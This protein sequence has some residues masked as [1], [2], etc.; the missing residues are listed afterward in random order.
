MAI[1]LLP[2]IR[3][4]HQLRIN[5]T[6]ILRIIM[7]KYILLQARND[8]DEMKIEELNSFAN[9]LDVTTN[10]ITP[11]NIFKDELNLDLLQ[12]HTALL[13]GGSGE[14]SVLDNN[15]HIKRFIDF[16]GEV[17]ER[18]FPTFAS[19][20]GFQ[21][22]T[23]ALG[24]KVIKDIPNA[25]VG[26]YDLYKTEDANNDPVFG[27]LPQ[28]FAAQLGHQDRASILPESVQCLAYSD[29]APF[30]ALKVIGRPV[31]A[32]QFHPELSYLENKQRFARYMDIYGKLFGEDKARERMDSHR[33]SEES[34]QLLLSF[35]AYIT[36][37]T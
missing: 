13:V 4:N 28:K 23:V 20:F 1:Y 3:L 29:K 18:S 8:N 14:Y 16:L 25:E 7:E 22:L 34:N 2:I 19:C 9:R 26:T 24:G 37:L 32:T 17:T 33:P 27:K 6:S 5:K 31:Y 12:S 21:A 11:I 15:V 10:Q 30:Q 35:R 36:E